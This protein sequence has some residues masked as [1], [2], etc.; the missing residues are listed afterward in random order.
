MKLK[1]LVAVLLFSSFFFCST[2]IATTYY[3]KHAT[4]NDE[5]AGTSTT[6]WAHCPGMAGWA[7]SASLQ[8]GDIVYFDNAST[9]SVTGNDTC[10]LRVVGG[11]TYNGSSW[12]SGT[13]AKFSMNDSSEWS[14]VVSFSRDH[15]TYATI[16]SGF[17]LD[18]NTSHVSGI[19][20]NQGGLESQVALTGTTKRIENCVI[21]N[22][23]LYSVGGDSDGC[24]HYGIRINADSSGEHHTKNVEIL[25]NR[26]YTTAGSAIAIYPADSYGTNVDQNAIDNVLI[27]GNEVYDSGI[28]PHHYVG[29]CLM[30]S[31]NSR[32]VVAEFN[33]FHNGYNGI[34]INGGKALGDVYPPGVQCTIRYNIIRNIGD[35]SG[36][37]FPNPAYPCP[38][39]A[40][41]G[42]NADAVLNIY[43]NIIYSCDG[44][45]ITLD[46]YTAYNHANP[47]NH[48][49]RIYNNTFYN[50]SVTGGNSELEVTCLDGNP[51]TT[52]EVKN[53]IF[54][55]K[56]SSGAYCV[57][58]NANRITSS[59]NNLYYNPAG[60]GVNVVYNGL[61]N[62]TRTTV[63]S[64][65]ETTSQNT[66]PTFKNTSNLPAGFIGTY[67]TNMVPDK[68][69]LSISM[70]NAL[71]NGADLGTS[72]KG[73]INLSGTNGGLTRSIGGSWDIGAYQYQSV[74][75]EMPKAP[76]GFK[77]IQ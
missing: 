44:V 4:G 15:A 53:N 24:Y 67:G 55:T 12:G 39:I 22:T 64:T 76:N 37:T 29:A 51:I 70:G 77:I 34:I 19:F 8:A 27:R 48:I 68:D 50:N 38:G 65:Y 32:N 63:K 28:S 21:H 56:N 60:S 26:V 18:G 25:N 2:A 72:Y 61:T 1:S 45:G 43:G 42:A 46:P 9:W 16:L 14:T 62:Y 41:Q 71:Y 66:D 11:V 57:Y 6:P 10:V 73:A 52:F 20:M 13:I 7:G 58:A 75:D 49:Y 31:N 36:Y 5:N 30:I 69:G 35:N 74:I 3:V 23:G 33:Y 40:L 59:T 17:E 47:T 54:M